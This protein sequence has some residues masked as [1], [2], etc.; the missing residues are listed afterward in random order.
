MLKFK[1]LDMLFL[2][3]FRLDYFMNIFYLNNQ[4]LITSFS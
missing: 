3:E 2:Y 4:T 1:F